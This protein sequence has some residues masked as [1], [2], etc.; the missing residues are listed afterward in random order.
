MNLF[1]VGLLFL[2]VT[3]KTNSLSLF[4]RDKREQHQKY[5]LVN[6]G[7][8]SPPKQK[9]YSF[10]GVRPEQLPPLSSKTFESDLM[11]EINDSGIDQKEHRTIGKPNITKGAM[12]IQRGED[13]IEHAYPYMIGIISKATTF[14]KL[15]D[16]LVFSKISN[17]I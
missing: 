10:L 3:T 6:L 1:I 16:F 8:E 7:P 2:F 4:G 14:L 15:I 5:P 12:K 13:A 17:R 9:W 11:K